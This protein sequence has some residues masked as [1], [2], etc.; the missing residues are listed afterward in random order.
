VTWTGPARALADR[1][2]AFID[3]SLA[4]RPHEPFEGLALD[5]HAWQA[6]HAPVVA[7][8]A[9]GE[10]AHWTQIPAVPVSLFKDLPVGTVREDEASV[11]FRTSGT[12][13]GGRGVHRLR[14]TALYDRGAVAWARR[15]VPGAPTRVVALLDDPA[16]VPDASL[17]HMVASFGAVTWTVRDG[18]L[19]APATTAAIATDEPIYVAST[20]FA[21]AE[22]L[23]HDP[24]ALPAGSVVMVTGGFKGRVHRLEGAS[25]YRA[26]REQLAPARLVTEYG[27]TELSSQLWG[28][29][30]TPYAPPPWLGV[31]A[32]DPVTGEVRPAGTEGQL[33]FVD[34]ANLDSTLGVE[35]MDAGVVFADG[36]VELRGRLAGAPS[37]GCSLTV[38]EAWG[39][40]SSG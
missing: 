35:T 36:T 16:R 11:A 2:G 9:L 21:M 34:L 27:M 28:T 4:G 30:G 8:L 37:R 22:Y 18:V 3:A 5:V 25:L 1:I 24:P 32:V 15:C 39:R 23:D 17:S 29:P 12:T 14:S 6:A 20:A 26:I 40:R 33:R 7:A 19:D 13:G 31:L 10:V 38:E